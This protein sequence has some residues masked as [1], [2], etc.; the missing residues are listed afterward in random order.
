M[1][2]TAEVVTSMDKLPGVT[3]Q[4]LVPNEKSLEN[5]LNLLAVRPDKPPA[6]AFSVAN[7]N[8]TVAESPKRL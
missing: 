3:N 7:T 5:V 1:A 2:G 4:V 6:N 8:V